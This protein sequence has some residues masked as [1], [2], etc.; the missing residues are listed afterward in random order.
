MRQ[1]SSYIPPTTIMVYLLI[2]SLSILFF[3]FSVTYIYHKVYSNTPEARIP[4]ILYFNTLLIIASSFTLAKAK[5]YFGQ[6]NIVPY[7]NSLILTLA[8]GL[9]FMAMQILSWWFLDMQGLGI[10]V[11]QSTSYL[12]LV[13]IVHMLHIIGGIPFIVKLTIKSQDA[14][15][16]PVKSLLLFS[17]DSKYLE[18]KNFS[19]YWHFVG[20]LWVYI[21]LF[22]SI[23]R[24]F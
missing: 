4:T 19:I 11:T 18:L 17:M 20:L 7:R 15:A 8:L 12:Y 9:V 3:V 6:N 22:F 5:K 23:I 21:I 1:Q 24:W 2:C 10:K 13:P 14:V 16:D